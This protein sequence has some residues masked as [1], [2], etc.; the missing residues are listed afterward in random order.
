M[1]KKDPTQPVAAT[2]IGALL[3]RDDKFDEAAKVLTG[4]L[5]RQHPN[6]QLLELLMRAH[7]E[8]EG[9]GRGG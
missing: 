3:I 1:L 7:R 9:L 4:A 8:A 5:D 2:V 6:Q